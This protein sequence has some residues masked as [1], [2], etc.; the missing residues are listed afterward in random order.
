MLIRNIRYLECGSIF[1]SNSSLGDGAF[2][3]CRAMHEAIKIIRIAG[4]F[5]KD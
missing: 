2:V 4:D 1:S 3:Q 5:L